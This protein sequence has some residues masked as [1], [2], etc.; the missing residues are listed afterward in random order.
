MTEG[1]SNEK[2]IATLQKHL[3][4]LQSISPVF[5]PQAVYLWRDI[6]SDLKEIDKLVND[7]R[8]QLIAV[9][10]QGQ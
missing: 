3:K 5:E 10:N 6:K 1:C 8:N 7:L 2:T 4:V 9:E